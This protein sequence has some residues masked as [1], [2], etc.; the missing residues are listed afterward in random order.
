MKKVYLTQ[1]FSF[2]ARH[3][4][5]GTLNESAHAHMFECEVTLH[6]PLNNEDYLIDFRSLQ[7]FFKKNIVARLDDTDLNTLFEHPTTETLTI[8][9]FEEIKKTFPQICSIKVAEAPDRWITY[10]GE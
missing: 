4:H 9:L 1:C 8:W 10:T 7:S 5:G 2:T 6:G 3:A